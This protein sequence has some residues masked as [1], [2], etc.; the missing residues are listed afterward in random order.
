MR[1]GLC[2]V[3]NGCADRNRIIIVRAVP[4]WAHQRTQG[5]LVAP[6]GCIA[7]AAILG[8]PDEGAVDL[9]TAGPVRFRLAPAPDHTPVRL[10]S[11][12]HCEHRL[13]RSVPE[14]CA[15]PTEE[16]WMRSTTVMVETLPPGA[17]IDLCQSQLRAIEPGDEVSTGRL[18]MADSRFRVAST[19][20]SAR[21]RS[22]ELAGGSNS[23]RAR[24]LSGL[25][26]VAENT[27]CLGP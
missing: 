14:E 17:A 22:H 25:D 26:Q 20:Q 18:V 15:G 13:D 4:E 19:G 10:E 6:Q 9:G 8:L 1:T 11:A 5:A 21:E 12:E 7:E 27:I 3:Q 16:L 23:G 24:R 2:T